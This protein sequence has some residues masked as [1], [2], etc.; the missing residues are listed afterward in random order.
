MRKSADF[1][2]FGLCPELLDGLEDMRIA[3]PALIQVQTIPLLL[4]GLDVVGQAAPGTENILAYLLPMLE[5][6]RL[7]HD[8]IQ[9]A[10]LAPSRERVH[11]IADIAAQLGRFRGAQILS[12]TEGT[13]ADRLIR[14]QEQSAHIVVATPDRLLEHMERGAFHP[15]KLS[16]LVL[17]EADQMLHKGFFPEMERIMNRA[18]KK[19]QAALFAE[20]IPQPIRQLVKKFMNSPHWVQ[21]ESP[22]LPLNEIHHLAVITTETDKLN[23]MTNLIVNHQPDL[24]LVFCKTKHRAQWVADA[25][26]KAGIEAEELHGDQPAVKRQQIMQRFCEAKIRVLAVTD[27]AVKELDAEGI[28]HVYNFDLPPD[29]RGYM[30]RIGRLGRV[31]RDGTAISLFTLDEAPLL[32]QIEKESGCPLEK[33]N[34]L[35]QP[36]S[37]K[38]EIRKRRPV[39]AVASVDIERRVHGKLR[40]TAP[41]NRVKHDRP[42]T[43]RKRSKGR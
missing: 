24:A 37:L 21:A 10:I 4:R 1:S 14:T 27:F 2:T 25:L 23:V 39:A 17:D 41:A 3:E 8:E 33:I 9:G 5:K 32:S 28:T 13:D 40:K 15:G 31:G 34:Q 7:Q 18:P 29:S 35:G 16:M 12:L 22:P 38:L 19:K 30:H 43:R 36:V 6:L 42:L 20:D 11:Q 26:T